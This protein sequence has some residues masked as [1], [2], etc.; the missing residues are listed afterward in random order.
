[1]PRWLVYSGLT[2]F[3]VVF[4]G[5]VLTWRFLSAAGYFTEIKAEIPADCHEIRSVPGP[6]DIVVDA[7]RGIAFVSALDRRAIM[8]GGKG[9]DAVRGGIYTIDLKGPRESWALAPVTPQAPDSFRPHGISLYEGADGTRRLFVVNHPAGKA[10]EVLI[11]DIGEDSRLTLVQAVHSSLL[12]SPNDV[13]AVGPESFYV[14]ND[15]GTASQTG[16]MIDDFLLLRNGNIAYYDG[17][18]MRV[19]ADTLGFPNGIN[20]SPD[21]MRIYVATTMEAALH[22][23]SRNPES[24]A[25]KAVDFARLGTGTDNIDVQPDG[26]LLIGAHPDLVQYMEHVED[27]KVLSPGQ[28][29]RVEPDP[30]GGGKAATIYLNKGEQIS[31]LSVAAGYKDQMLIGA[32]FQPKILACKQSTEMKAY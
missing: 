3:A 1:M 20:V 31:G 17:S 6:E 14:T 9:T 4:V 12:V 18:E 5:S 13:V 26:T 8:A 11:Y 7:K 19:V 10:D 16:Q 2:V 21:G 27:P 25:L 24:G 29:V 15:H 22:V 30:K 28:V 32:V 23:Y